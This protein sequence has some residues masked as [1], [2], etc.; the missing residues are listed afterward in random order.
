MP[1]TNRYYVYVEVNLIV[2]SKIRLNLFQAHGVTNPSSGVNGQA[3]PE[4]LW[5]AAGD[6]DLGWS[7]SFVFNLFSFYGK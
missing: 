7:H 2:I 1:L 4:V 3:G 5:E 6:D